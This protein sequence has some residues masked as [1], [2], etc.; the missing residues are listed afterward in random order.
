MGL[1]RLAHDKLTEFNVCVSALVAK[2]DKYVQ[3]TPPERVPLVLAPIVQMVKL[4]FARIQ[5][6]A[7]VFRQLDFQI[8]DM[9]RFWFEAIAMLDYMEIYRP[10]MD[11]LVPVDPTSV[12]DTMGVFTSDVRVA[13][14]HFNAGLPYWFIRPA[15][16]LNDQNILELRQLELPHDLHLEPHPY[17]RVVLA[18]GRAGTSE[19]FNAIHK[20]ARN[21]LKYTDPFEMGTTVNI[22]TTP[23]PPV[24]ASHIAGSSSSLGPTRTVQEKNIRGQA[25]IRGTRG[26]G[27][28]K[29]Q[30]E[31]VYTFQ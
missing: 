3:E 6:I 25:G 16:A 18:E 13:Q 7:M 9:Q 23:T 11:G 14:D 30:S 29:K 26:R 27:R 17:R 8:R 20:Y 24:D 19:K 10:R 4:S 21:H 5:A 2:V 12:A 28:G 15:S 31:T 22:N 1:G